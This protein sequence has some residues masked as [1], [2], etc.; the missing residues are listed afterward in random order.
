MLLP[1]MHLYSVGINKIRSKLQMVS[2]SLGV[3]K[4]EILTGEFIKLLSFPIFP[5]MLTMAWCFLQPCQLTTSPFNL[6]LRSDIS[7]TID[8]HLIYLNQCG[9]TGREKVEVTIFSNS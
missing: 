6:K 9:N 2:Y 5:N 7:L 8:H 3:L 4:V 1:K